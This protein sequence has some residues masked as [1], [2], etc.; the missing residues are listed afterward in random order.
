MPDNEIY[1]FCKGY[2]KL[3]NSFQKTMI[4]K[5]LLDIINKE[6]DNFIGN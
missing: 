6:I 2:K 4:E 1:N 3:Q 5:K